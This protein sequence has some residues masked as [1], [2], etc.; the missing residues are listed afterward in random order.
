MLCLDIGSLK[1]CWTPARGRAIGYTVLLRQSD[2]YLLSCNML[3][4]L[5]MLLQLEYNKTVI[6]LAFLVA[7]LYT[8]VGVL[9]LGFLI[10]FLR[11]VQPCMQ[12]DAH[13]LAMWCCFLA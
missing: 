4:C 8:A 11:Y 5:C 12:H 6:Q 2:Q 13:V 10:R 1:S 3:L 9:R 7:C